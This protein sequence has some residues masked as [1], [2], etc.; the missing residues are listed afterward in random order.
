MSATK[1]RTPMNGVIGMADILLSTRLTPEQL[2]YAATIRTSGQAP[3]GVI[4]DILDFSKIEAGKLEVEQISLRS[5]GGSRAGYSNSY[6]LDVLP[7]KKALTFASISISSVPSLI[8]GDPAPF[9]PGALEPVGNAIKFTPKGFVTVGKD[10]RCRRYRR[11]NRPG[12]RRGQ[13]QWNWYR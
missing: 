2:D 5:V 10:I 12:P 7:R 9:S 6:K 3:L 11:I 4:N 8:V 1:I 13:G